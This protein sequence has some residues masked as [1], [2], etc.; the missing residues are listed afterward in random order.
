MLGI[1]IKEAESP[2][3]HGACGLAGST[4]RASHGSENVRHIV[5]ANRELQWV[6]LFAHEWWRVKKGFLGKG[7]PVLSLRRIIQGMLEA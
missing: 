5:V 6:L 7:I 4:S 3:G 1:Q 2:Q